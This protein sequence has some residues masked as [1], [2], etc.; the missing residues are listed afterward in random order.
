[1]P[2][3]THDGRSFMLDGRRIWLASGRIPYA[4]LARESWG[5]RIRAAKLAGLNCVETPIFWNRHEVRPGKFDFNGDNDIRHFLDLVGQ[6]GM[7]CILGLG[8]YVGSEWDFG[9]LPAWLS[10]AANAG[11]M[12]LRSNSGPFLESCSRF[13]N[14]I[15]DQVRGWQITTP[16]G[17]GNIVLLQIENEWTCGHDT[18]PHAYLGELLRYCREAGLNV[19]VLNSNNLWQNVEGQ[20]DAWAGNSDMLATMRQLA[21]VRPG[22]PR[23]VIDFS[24]SNPEIIGRPSPSRL[25]AH[26]VER[27][28]AEVLAA[29]GQFNIQN[30]AGGTN[31][32]FGGGRG[33]D[34]A[35]SFFTTRADRSGVLDEAG[36]PT[37]LHSA[38]RRIAHLASRFGRIFANLDPAYHPIAL[39]PGDTPSDADTKPA[40]KASHHANPVSV[41]HAT[42]SQGS[43]VFLLSQPTAEGV[44]THGLSLLR[45]DGSTLGVSVPS[46]GVAWCLFDVNL[47]G[48]ARLDYCNLSVFGLV[49]QSL[50]CFGPPGAPAL[51][52]INGSPVEGS[53]PTNGQP[54]IIETESLTVVILPEELVDQT[55]CDDS[56]VFVGVTGLAG[57]GS[58][59]AAANAKTVTRI[60]PD[61]KHK[62]LHAEHHRPKAPPAKVSLGHWAVASTDDYQRGDSARYAAISALTELSSL[63]C[64]SGYGWY[65]ISFK[66][67]STG[68]SS[69]AFPKGGDRLHLFLDGKAVAVS[70]VGPGAEPFGDISVKKGPHTLVILAD[71]LGRFSAGN[72]LGE[73]KGVIGDVLEVEPMKPG[74]PKLVRG[75]PIELLAWRA[76]LW[77]ISEGDNTA[78]ERLTWTLPH[79]GKMPVVMVID[80]PPAAAVVCVND[81][82]I[83]F[84][85]RAGP[86][87]LLLSADQ[88]GKG[89]ATVQLALGLGADEDEIKRISGGISF[90]EA[91]T[92]INAKADLAFA[93]WEQP[94]TG[95]YEPVK[96]KTKMHGP[97]WYKCEFTADKSHAPLFF[98]PEGLTKGQFYVND[99]HVGRYFVATESGKAVGPQDKYYIPDSWLKAGSPNELVIFDEHG[100]SPSHVKLM[101]V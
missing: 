62:S 24:I 12:T 39:V 50:V 4:R 20:I 1:M 55:I 91:T 54:E 13:I 6:H 74:A 45:P 80:E 10:E 9:G 82:P 85:D 96:S 52:S 40:K 25:N 72:H 57:D 56:G 42:G 18:L 7:Y 97:A 32:A 37:D 89:K 64:P 84:V 86:R 76:P 67:E 94:P 100:A 79:K 58:P 14:A 60:G 26:Q 69:L 16:A 5:E 90:Y 33:D 38:V 28:L 101:H 17:G 66:S 23:F 59:I 29:G 22:S 31:F 35:S 36:R 49:G 98:I 88:L 48:R 53:V 44:G 73:S 99:R 92:A 19:P 41:L 2:S 63:G 8:P 21:V 83:A 61:G 87:Q 95:A 27:R 51:L 3:V 30:F 43:V 47:T 78:V 34:G 68:K 93:R 75:K 15:A 46:S 11:K 70:G 77:E 81:T 71:N 65:R